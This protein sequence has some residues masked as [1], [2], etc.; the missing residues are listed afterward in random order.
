M[1]RRRLMISLRVTVLLAYLGGL[2][3]CVACPDKP[4]GTPVDP[5]C[6]FTPEQEAL[7]RQMARER[8]ERESWD[9][10]RAGF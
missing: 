3:G 6:R 10:E 9:R 1:C 8:Q 7:H 2:A 4:P 5:A